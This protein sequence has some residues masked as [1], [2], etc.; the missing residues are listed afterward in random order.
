MDGKPPI[1]SLATT[2]TTTSNNVNEIS[3]NTGSVGEGLVS[4]DSI[5]CKKQ[6]IG[7][8][9]LIQTGNYAGRKAT[10]TRWLPGWMEVEIDNGELQCRRSHEL[11]LLEP[12]PSLPAKS[13]GRKNKKSSIVTKT[14]TS[15]LTNSAP[16]EITITSKKIKRLSILYYHHPRQET[17]GYIR[18]STCVFYLQQITNKQ[19][20]SNSL[21][22][23]LLSKLYERR[24]DTLFTCHGPSKVPMQK[25]WL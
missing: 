1:E 20:Q 24:I 17:T 3:N 23:I 12:I 4:L 11:C 18:S 16:D 7:K 8:R 10:T 13:K 22:F 25:I 2:T 9:V 15:S 14:T 21:Y 6:L 5:K 19:H